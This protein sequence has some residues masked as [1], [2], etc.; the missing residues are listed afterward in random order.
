MSEQPDTHAKELYDQAY[1]AMTQ[2]N[3]E[4]AIRLFEESVRFVPHYRSLLHLGECYFQLGKLV[5]SVVP[6]AAA[7]T[8]NR[9]GIA[10]ALLAEVFLELGDP[11]KAKELVDL[12]VARQPDYK[13]A[14]TLRNRV[15]QAVAEWNQRFGF[16]LY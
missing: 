15:D 9:Q 6:L 7:T 13:R 16:D 12:A 10:P 5:E 8:L 3:F 14:K 2:S 11:R 1:E 4:E